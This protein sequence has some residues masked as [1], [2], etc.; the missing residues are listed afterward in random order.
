MTL[1]RS[2]DAPTR[3][4]IDQAVL[5]K[6]EQIRPQYMD[7]TTFINFQLDSVLS[8]GSQAQPGDPSFI[9]SSSFSKAVP[10]NACALPVEKK[11]AKK[12]DIYASKNLSAELVPADLQQHAELLVDFWSVKKG[13]RSGRAWDGLLKALRA[14]T[15][16]NQG[17]A[18]TAA[19]N[20]GWATV[21]EPTDTPK[22]GRWKEPETNH[23]AHKVFKADDL[24][25]EWD[26]PSTTGGKGVLDGLF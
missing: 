24:G 13:T 9:S 10:S 17:K 20:A 26:I 21:Y 14:M 15:P 11:P 12:K 4:A 23:P 22:Q 1:P 16:E 25:P 5:D 2:P 18:L 19:Y 8:L 6:L 3:I 7:R